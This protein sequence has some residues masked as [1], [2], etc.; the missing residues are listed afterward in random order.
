[1]KFNFPRLLLCGLVTLQHFC[2]P[3]SVG[4]KDL[5]VAMVV[6]RGETEAEKGF[7]A[8]LKALGYAVQYTV[9]NAGQDRSELGRLLRD[10]LK[11]NLDKFDY[12]YTFGTTVSKSAKSI[13]MNKTPQIY[14]IVTDP[15]GAGIVKSTEASGENVTGV[16]LAIPLSMQIQTAL[17]VIAF[18]RLGFMFN[19][20]EKNSMLV[21][22]KLNSVAKQSQ[23]EIVD[24]R[25]PPAQEMLQENLEKLKS[26]AIKVDAV[27]LPSDSFLASKAKF[28]GETLVAAKI[29][30]I[31]SLE[32]YIEKG[33]LMGVVPDY[34]E[35][36]QIAAAIVHRKERGEQFS[37][38]PMQATKHPQ[39]MINRTTANTLNV[40][41]PEEMLKKAVV[42]D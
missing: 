12:V 25:S 42:V 40:K 32:T 31:A 4:A 19:P 24:L 18:R 33:A 2:A 37:L 27:Y 8:G 10:E 26:K 21:R 39:L 11:S 29:T 1:M 9:I 5:K 17:K 35:L 13:V 34:F 22:D 38:I 23:F 3:A 6:W 36:G 30:S 20:R 14:N 16:T 15:V 28:I 41:M 7:R